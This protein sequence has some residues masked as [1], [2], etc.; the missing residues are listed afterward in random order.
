MNLRINARHGSREQA[1]A[2]LAVHAIEADALRWCDEGIV[3]REARDV[4]ALPGF[5]D[6]LLSV[7]DQAAQLAAQL[8]DVQPGQRFLDACATP[9]G[10]FA[11]VLETG[12]QIGLAVA[13]SS[14]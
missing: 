4:S 2:R 7:Q 11:H 12:A 5:A 9:G 14:R 8:L 10:K 3:L 13:P 1:I 6:G